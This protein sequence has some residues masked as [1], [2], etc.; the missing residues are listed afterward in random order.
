MIKITYFDV[1]KDS[2]SDYQLNGPMQDIEN[3]C[4]KK[5]FESWREAPTKFL[6]SVIL[7]LLMRYLWT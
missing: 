4:N 5:N 7:V 1:Q 6:M 2:Q 3:W